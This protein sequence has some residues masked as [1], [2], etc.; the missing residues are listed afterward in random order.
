MVPINGF[1]LKLL[2][3]IKTINASS[4]CN[5]QL[6]VANANEIAHL[7]NLEELETGNGLNQTS[8]LQRPVET[9]WNSHFRRAY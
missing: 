8:T 6:K 4:K 7:I 3:V 9:R 1:F 2:L 5:E